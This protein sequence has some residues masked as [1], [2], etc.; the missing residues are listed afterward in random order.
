MTLVD[1]VRLN[2]GDA[3]NPDWFGLS[4]KLSYQKKSDGKYEIYLFEFTK[5][6]E[7]ETPGSPSV[8]NASWTFEKK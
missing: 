6:Y 5:T 4:G 3:A 1:P 8:I 2:D 7:V